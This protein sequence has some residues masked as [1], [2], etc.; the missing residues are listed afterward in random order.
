MNKILFVF[1]FVLLLL[2]KSK[3]AYAYIDPGMGSLI[4]QIFIGCIIGV[5]FATKKFFKKIFGKFLKKD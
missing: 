3:E 1:L 4:L 2:L 5:I